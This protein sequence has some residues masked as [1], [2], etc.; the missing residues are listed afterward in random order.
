MGQRIYRWV[1]SKQL[2]SRPDP[3]PLQVEVL[4]GK[5]LVAADRGGTSDPYV[6]VTVRQL[7]GQTWKT[8]WIKKTLN[9]LWNQ[10]FL[11]PVAS[12]V[13]ISSSFFLELILFPGS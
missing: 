2:E 8:A 12:A 9:P 7:A 11:I 10:S 1:N 6:I 4:E 5:S 13:S 3:M